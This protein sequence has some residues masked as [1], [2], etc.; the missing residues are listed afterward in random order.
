M[1]L[2]PSGHTVMVSAILFTGLSAV[3]SWG[4]ESLPFTQRPSSQERPI[5]PHLSP[6]AALP[7]PVI[8]LQQRLS[9][10]P[11][12]PLSWQCGEFVSAG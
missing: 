12:A 6:E 11:E 2:I 10:A 7:S 4:G 8:Q 3:G 1:A 9:V 5:A